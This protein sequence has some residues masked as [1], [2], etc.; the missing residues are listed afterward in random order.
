[1]DGDGTPCEVNLEGVPAALFI[2]SQNHQHDLLRECALMDIGNRWRLT[3]SGLPHKVADMIAEI[4]R[5]YAEVR[6]TTRR[7]ALDALAEGHD[8]VTLSVPVRPGIVEALHRWLELVETA[9][10]YCNQGT[11]LTLA[12]PPEVRALRR[13]YVRAIEQQLTSREV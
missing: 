2:Q 11:L 1:M 5:D 7:Q 10:Q 3:D 6:S 12:A 8:T 9:D 13:W 4:L